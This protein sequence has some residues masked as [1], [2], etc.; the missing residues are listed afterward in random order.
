MAWLYVAVLAIFGWLMI[1]RRL[2]ATLALPLAAL[3]LALIALAPQ[4]GS[5]GVL[6]ALSTLIGEVVEPG[7][8]RLTS[9]IIA[10]ILGAVLAAQMRI[11]G[12]AERIVRYGAEYAGEDQFRLGLLLLAVIAVLFTTLGGLGAVILAASITLPLMFAL[13]FEPKVAGGLFLLGLSLG[14]CL[15]PVNWQLYIDVLGLELQQIVPFAVLLAAIFFLIACGYLL[16]YTTSRNTWLR[17]LLPLGLFL[18]LVTASIIVIV[19]LEVWDA[20]K[21][22]LAASMLAILVALML[23]L[24]LRIFLLLIPRRGSRAGNWLSAQD[25]WLTCASILV[26]LLLLL[27]STLHDNL[28]GDS[29]RISIPILTAL[30][31][32]IAFCAL[33]SLTRESGGANNLM[34]ALFEGVGQA[35]PAIV[36]IIGIGLLLKATS[37][38]EVSGSF[39]PWLVKLPVGS[40]P[41]FV[42]IFFLLSPLA[43]YRGP[44]NL[45]GMGSG[46]VGIISGSAILGTNLI[47]VAFLSVG[48][49]QGVCDPTNTHNVWIANFCKV[50]VGELTR[51]TL[52]W[53]LAIVLLGLAAGAAVFYGSFDLPQL[54]PI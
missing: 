42:A 1:S 19:K 24:L 38:P 43:L 18:A 2:T 30:M 52:P 53:V 11:S 9:L 10:V 4:A 25:N 22:F 54:K 39:T 16:A 12:A 51:I 34:R 21:H 44:L 26:P 40:A 13:G 47:M 46:V 35:A 7:L 41:G 50:P 31:A 27:W 45:Y 37:L 28:A 15:N 20:V 5:S 17:Q 23:I 48:M 32:G 49:L 33:A 14:G 29:A 8:T 36:L 3:T 6:A